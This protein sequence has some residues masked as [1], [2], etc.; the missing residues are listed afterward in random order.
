MVQQKNRIAKIRKILKKTYPDVK[1]ALHHRNPVQ[2]LIATILS[3]Q[4]TDVRVNQVTPTLFKELPAAKD[5][6]EVPLSDLEEM[7]RPTGFYRNGHD[8]S[9][10]DQTTDNQR[11]C[12][13][14]LHG[15]RDGAKRLP[16]DGSL[17]RHHGLDLR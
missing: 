16:G 5:F 3:A 1:T 15:L 4:C 14:L 13:A 2:L 12:G 10:S 6:A 8:F 17:C 7:I 11:W 9:P